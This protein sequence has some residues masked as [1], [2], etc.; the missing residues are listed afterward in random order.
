M[1]QRPVSNPEEWKDGEQG[2]KVFTAPFAFTWGTSDWPLRLC[3]RL[4]SQWWKNISG[5]MVKAMSDVALEWFGH[6][7]FKMQIAGK[8]LFFDP[9][10]KNTLLG[11]TLEPATENNISAIFISHEH[12]DHYDADTILALT[13]PGTKTHFPFSVA[14]PFSCRLTFEVE[15]KQSLKKLTQSFSPVRINDEI[16][17]DDIS[18][19]CLEAT[20]GL[21]FLIKYGQK[22][23]LFM[24]DS[25]ALE[26]MIEEKPDII[27]FP[28][29]AV[30]GEESDMENF[31]KLAGESIC[32]PMHFHN[33]P[34][35]LPNFF[36]ESDKLQNLFPQNIK[37]KVLERNVPVEF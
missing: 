34:D 7:A 13:S 28:I 4:V 33:N 25:I 35:S 5:E 12:W 27:L 23:I 3:A 6:A 2:R 36:I 22:K 11:T 37:L 18:V 32:V 19:K 21:S 16:E 1:T 24:G 14:S 8:I 9:V 29:W 30:E 10:R 15:D 31:L 17:I 20:E 26:D